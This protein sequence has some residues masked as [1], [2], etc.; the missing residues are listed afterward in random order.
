M[1]LASGHGQETM[2]LASKRCKNESGGTT[3]GQTRLSTR[4]AV[5]RSLMFNLSPYGYAPPST[6][7]TTADYRPC[8]QPTRP[9]VVKRIADG[10]FPPPPRGP[11]NLHLQR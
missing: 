7:S 11:V 5:N 2:K 8:R 3:V 4:A 6:L 10:E 1:S 9:V